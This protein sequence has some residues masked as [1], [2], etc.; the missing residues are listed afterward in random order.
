[1]K[2]FE[3]SIYKVGGAYG[4]TV[5]L[6][7]TARERGRGAAAADGLSAR[8][9]GYSAAPRQARGTNPTMVLERAITPISLTHWA[10]SECRSAGVAAPEDSRRGNCPLTWTCGGYGVTRAFKEVY[11]L[12]NKWTNIHIVG[13]IS[14]RN[15]DHCELI[16]NSLF[17]HDSVIHSQYTRL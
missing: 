4:L 6:P 9:P 11:T 10:I 1:M 14:D 7:G 15:R 13:R 16:T 12:P 3:C 2:A 17:Y 5:E 8:A